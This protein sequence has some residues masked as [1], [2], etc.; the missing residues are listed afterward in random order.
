M[1]VCCCNLT[2][3]GGSVPGFGPF[4]IHRAMKPAILD[5]RKFHGFGLS[6]APSLAFNKEATCGCD[7]GPR[8]KVRL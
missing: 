6:A 1:C 4:S 7:S 2:K 5:S 3:R 8:S